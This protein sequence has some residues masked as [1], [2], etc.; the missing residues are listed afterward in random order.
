MRWIMGEI[1]FWKRILCFKQ[2]FFASII[3]KVTEEK[4]NPGE[5]EK[6]ERRKKTLQNDS[7]H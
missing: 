7:V 4:K 3:V 1:S 5:N 6:Q 2:F